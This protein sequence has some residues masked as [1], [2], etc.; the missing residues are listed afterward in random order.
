MKKR[1]SPSMLSPQLHTSTSSLNDTRFELSSPERTLAST[2]GNPDS[3]EP[4]NL[5]TS[6][7][8]T[9]EEYNKILTDFF[10]GDGTNFEAEKR[11]LDLNGEDPEERVGKRGRR[12]D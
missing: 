3:R 10:S 6:L 2:L 7:G 12:F 1:I 9:N 8:I 5:F 4:E 11:P